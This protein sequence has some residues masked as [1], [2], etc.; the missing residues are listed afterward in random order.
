MDESS[1]VA[2]RIVS[3][4]WVWGWLGLLFGYITPPSDAVYDRGWSSL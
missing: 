4:E 2:W 1:I 3:G